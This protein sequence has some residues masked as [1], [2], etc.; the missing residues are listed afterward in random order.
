MEDQDPREP[1]ELTPEE[2]AQVVAEV[3]RGEFGLLDE[4]VQSELERQHVYNAINELRNVLA[5]EQ[6]VLRL[7]QQ[8]LAPED[9]NG[10]NH[11]EQIKGRLLKT[12]K[13]LDALVSMIGE[14]GPTGFPMPSKLE[15]VSNRTKV[16]IPVVVVPPDAAG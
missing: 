11:P 13:R 15:V 2:A 6:I 12:R 7:A 16:E 1:L 4:E 14:I 5:S 9:P 3:A 10:K 8:G